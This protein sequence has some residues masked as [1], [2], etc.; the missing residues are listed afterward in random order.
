MPDYL[1]S[2]ATEETTSSY[3]GLYSTER[4]VTIAAG[5]APINLT[6][7]PNRHGHTASS[8][9]LTSKYLFTANSASHDHTASSPTITVNTVTLPPR[10]TG[11]LA[12]A[13]SNTI[14]VTG[15]TVSPLSY[16][17][18]VVA[19]GPVAYFKLNEPSGN[20]VDT[21]GGA[22]STPVGAGIVYGVAGP[23]GAGEAVRIDGS[24]SYIQTTHSVFIAHPWSAEMWV[25][26]PSAI[27][28]GWKGLIVANSSYGL[29]HTGSFRLYGMG[30]VEE[31]IF[32]LMDNAWH[33]VT[34]SVQSNGAAQ[35][36]IDGA[37]IAVTGTSLLNASAVRL[38]GHG[39]EGLSGG[40]L[41]RVSLWNRAVT[42]AEH[43]ER[44]AL[45]P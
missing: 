14:T 33:L 41:S 11:V 35:V 7:N 15:Y 42:L 23:L 16:D 9:A 2:V 25:Y 10:P 19:A 3:V 21:M 27:T 28:T 6:P 31:N 12:V 40:S 36:F 26:L 43:Q 37:A 38:G 22:T 45:V 39:L 17:A 20:F 29:Y 18:T 34:L 1:W 32:N 4:S 5:P 44:W 30:F 13:S 24:E 8:P